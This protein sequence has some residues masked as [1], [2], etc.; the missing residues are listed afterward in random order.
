MPGHGRAAHGGIGLF[1]RAER[2][3]RV[4]VRPLAVNGG[5]IMYRRGGDTGGSGLG[6]AIARSIVRGHGG[7]IML[8]NRAEGG[9]RAAV[10]LPGAERP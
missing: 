8:A 3:C 10:A 2:T 7:D 4:Q 6:L 1:Q 9:L 5:V